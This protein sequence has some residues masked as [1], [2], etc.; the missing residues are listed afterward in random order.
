MRAGPRA[1]PRRRVFVLRA[2]GTWHAD[3][4][5]VGCVCACNPGPAARTLAGHTNTVRLEVA[6][7]RRHSFNA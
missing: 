4:A 1:R 2:D 5:R 3:G 6:A 7:E